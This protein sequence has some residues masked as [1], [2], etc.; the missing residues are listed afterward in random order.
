[1]T[2]TRIHVLINFI[3]ISMGNSGIYYNCS[4]AAESVS[5]V[6]GTLAR[7]QRVMDSR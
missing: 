3:E 7:Q 2:L 5:T 6:V 4:Y 1:V